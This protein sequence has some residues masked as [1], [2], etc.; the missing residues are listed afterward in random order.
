VSLVRNWR[1]RHPRPSGPGRLF[2]LVALLVLVIIFMLKAPEIVR[3]FS[4]VFF[5]AADSTETTDE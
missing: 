5:P 2:L 1:E 3:T 4:A